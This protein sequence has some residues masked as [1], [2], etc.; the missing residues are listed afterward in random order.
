IKL[1]LFDDRAGSKTK[2]ELME[3]YLGPENYNLVVVPPLVWNG[4]KGVAAHPSLVCNIASLAHDPQ[5]I[6]RKDPF[7]KDIPYDWAIKHG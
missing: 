3:L 7:T 1:V 5:E 4:F 6:Q 2:G